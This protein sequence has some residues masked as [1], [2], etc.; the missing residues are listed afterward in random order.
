MAGHGASHPVSLA[1]EAP[2]LARLGWTAKVAMELG[3]EV[4]LSR[5]GTT[6]PKTRSRTW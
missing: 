5:G 3:L 4:W 1:L 6:M 2:N